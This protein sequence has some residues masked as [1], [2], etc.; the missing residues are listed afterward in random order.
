MAPC[1]WGAQPTSLVDG[2]LAEK[3]YGT[4][5]VSERHRHRYEFNNN[6]RQQFNANGM[7]VSGTSP[8]NSLVEIVEIENHPWFLAVQF[9]PEFKSQPTNAHPLFAA[10]IAASIEQKK[11]RASDS[12]RSVETASNAGS[13]TVDP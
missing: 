8:D 13:A 5:E 12:M 1:D 10:F 2:S 7:D 6:Y 9:H 3:A 4:A 11:R